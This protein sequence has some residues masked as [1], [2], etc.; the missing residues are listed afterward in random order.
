LEQIEIDIGNSADSKSF[1]V[2]YGG[3]YLTTIKLNT[4]D[5]EQGPPQAHASSNQNAPNN[6]MDR[7][8]GSAAS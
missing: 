1:D 2:N 8:G 5:Y 3:K 4:Y 7:G 6:P